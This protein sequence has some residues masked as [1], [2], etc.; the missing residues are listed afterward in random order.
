[1]NHYIAVIEKDPDSAYGVS[2]PQ[3]EGVFSAGDTFEEA[4]RNANEALQLFFEDNPSDR[5]TPW[6]MDQVRNL[7]DVQ[8]DLT[9]GAMLVAIPYIELTGR[10]VR[11]NLT[12][13]AGLLVAID[14]E[15]KAR[16]ISRSAF[17]ASASQAMLNA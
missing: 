13:D 16:G 17:I 3:L 14:E 12:F 2:F 5:P 9:Q 10:T 1:M 7:E 15:A 8:T 4:T 6:T 11:A